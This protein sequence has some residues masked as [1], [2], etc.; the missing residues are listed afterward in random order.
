MAVTDSV[1]VPAIVAAAATALLLL[2]S[3]PNAV[4]AQEQPPDDFDFGRP[5][6]QDNDGFGR[7]RPNDPNPFRNRDFGAADTGRFDIDE[8]GFRRQQ[9]QG[10]GQGGQF[11][12]GGGGS[13]NNNVGF[14]RSTEDP[15]RS[16]GGSGGFGQQQ[17]GRNDDDGDLFNRPG[18]REEP[19]QVELT[20]RVQTFQIGEKHQQNY[21]QCSN[22]NNNKTI[23]N[24]SSS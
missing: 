13:D 17:P 5:R 12:G 9:G 15:F 2:T 4:R 19:E 21:T 23:I 24:C 18:D 1:L 16:G 6:Q 14:G 3:Q 7:P 11:G 20:E 10:G 22:S 8:D